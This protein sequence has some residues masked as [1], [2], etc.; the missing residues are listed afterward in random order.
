MVR[1]RL[2][3]LE[4]LRMQG[5]LG[6]VDLGL[7]VGPG[8]TLSHNHRAHRIGDRVAD[9]DVRRLLEGIAPPLQTDRAHHRLGD[10]GRDPFDVA[11]E[12]CERDQVS[13]HR[14]PRQQGRQ[15]PIVVG[16]P[17]TQADLS[18]TF[19]GSQGLPGTDLP[20]MI[21]LSSKAAGISQEWREVPE[22]IRDGF[23]SSGELSMPA[24]CP[25]PISE[26][27]TQLISGDQRP[28]RLAE[29]LTSLSEIYRQRASYQRQ[30][31]RLV[32]P[33]I[34][35]WGLIIS[36]ITLLLY[37]IL[38]PLLLEVKGTLL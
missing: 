33:Q 13:A 18:K 36:V 12:G 15:I 38:N 32:A 23:V 20:N 14:T 37:A 6:R 3:G 31:S 1:E 2:P 29:E 16:L 28:D 11:R 8:Q 30:L 9:R 7:Q 27:I 10:R 21:I 35:G 24:R 34:I 25:E 4:R 17:G 22:Q 26:C 5:A 19:P